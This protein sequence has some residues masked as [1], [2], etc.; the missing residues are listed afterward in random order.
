[1]NYTII[2]DTSDEDRW[3]AERLTGIGA[4]EIAAVLGESHWGSALSVYQEKVTGEQR[5]LSDVE[6]VEWG[7]RLEPLIID[8]Y[9]DRT[10]RRTYHSGLLLRSN[11]HQWALCTLD[12][13]T[14]E[15]PETTPWPLEVKTGA[16]WKLDDWADGPPRPYALQLQ[17]QMLVTGAPKATIA[18]LIGGQKLVWCDVERDESEIRR[19]I[20]AGSALW[21]RIQRRDPPP[22][23]GSEASGRA[24]SRLYPTDDGS[25]VELGRDIAD[26]L[27]ELERAK[28]E[29]KAAAARKATLEQQI[30]AAIGPATTAYAGGWTVSYKLQKRA[31]HVV[32]ASEFRVLR[33]KAAKEM[34]A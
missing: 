10:K 18:C 19:I 33:P 13:S 7:H 27:D 34:A 6:A 25:T 16:S 26:A 12:G 17:Q 5:D 11:E 1:M 22:P 15:P 14:V 24:L 32:K 2:C 3:L 28:A 8:A 29:E 9:A 4:S 31:E 23:D 30:K 21:E 20:A